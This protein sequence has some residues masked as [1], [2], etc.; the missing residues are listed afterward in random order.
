MGVWVAAERARHF[1]SPG[2]VVRDTIETYRIFGEMK[3]FQTIIAGCFM[4]IALSGCVRNTV[5][6]IAPLARPI[7]PEVTCWSP[8]DKEHHYLDPKETYV[9]RFPPPELAKAQHVSGCAAIVFQ[10]TREGKARNISL[11]RERPVGYGYGTF[12]AEQTR[13]ATFA[14]PA[15]ENDWYY[16]AESLTFGVAPIAPVAPVHS[17]FR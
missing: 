9:P 15:S 4:A 16:R 17:P 2:C 5:V 13:R 8:E 14:P 12:V 1:D 7:T 10:L 6:I 11:L 3:E